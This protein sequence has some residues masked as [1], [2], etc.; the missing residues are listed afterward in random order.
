[1]QQQLKVM[2]K[3]KKITDRVKSVLDAYD[4]LG[5]KREDYIPAKSIAMSEQDHEYFVAL[6]D[7][8]IICKALCE[9]WVANWGDSNQRKYYPWFYVVPSGFSFYVSAYDYSCPAVGARLC[10]PTSELATY[11]G[12]QFIDLWK[13]VITK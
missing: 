3:S 5:I 6:T 9:K 13:I 2:K 10:V 4:V 1:M 8:T 7:L 11:V 12:T